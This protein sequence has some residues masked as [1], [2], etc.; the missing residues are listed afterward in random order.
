MNQAYNQKNLGGSPDYTQQSLDI[1]VTS[2]CYYAT[3]YESW[4]WKIQNPEAAWWRAHQL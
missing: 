3:V 1:L 4:P 2:H